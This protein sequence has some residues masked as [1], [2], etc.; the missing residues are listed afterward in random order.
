M[1]QVRAAR[2][3]D[4]VADGR[5]VRNAALES[6]G[7]NFADQNDFQHRLFAAL[8]RHDRHAR[9]D[10][11]HAGVLRHDLGQRSDLGAGDGLTGNMRRQFDLGVAARHGDDA[12]DD[13]RR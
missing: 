12:A 13:L 4:I 7:Q 5:E 9:N 10:A 2:Q 11:D 6:A 1:R 3:I 8:A